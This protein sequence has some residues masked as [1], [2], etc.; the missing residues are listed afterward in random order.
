MSRFNETVNRP[1]GG[2]IFG[3]PPGIGCVCNG[4]GI[5]RGPAGASPLCD[6][7]S[8]TS[9]LKSP[10]LNL[11]TEKQNSNDSQSFCMSHSYKTVVFRIY[12]KACHNTF[13]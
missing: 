6:S 11:L 7:T 3:G 5:G 9:A 2:G 13:H 4:G 1:G 12:G 8:S 10:E